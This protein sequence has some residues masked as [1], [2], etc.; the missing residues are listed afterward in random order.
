MESFMVLVDPVLC[1]LLCLYGVRAGI[2]EFIDMT[3]PDKDVRIPNWIVIAFFAF[4]M[5]L[6][7]I[8]FLLRFRDERVLK[9]AEDIHG[10]EAGL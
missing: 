6:L 10:S 2:I 9:L 8:E 7:A 3:L 1:L 5:V 4:S